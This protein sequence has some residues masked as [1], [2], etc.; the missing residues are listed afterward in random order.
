MEKKVNCG[1]FRGSCVQIAMSHIAE[2]A[3][4]KAH[5]LAETSQTLNIGIN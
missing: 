5:G 2:C 3:F 1:K 4:D